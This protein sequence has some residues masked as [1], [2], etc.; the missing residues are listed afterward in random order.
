MAPS[1]RQTIALCAAALLLVSGCAAVLALDGDGEPAA[2]PSGD[3]VAASFQTL[4]SLTATEVRTVE[5]N[6]TTNRTRA[7]VKLA[8][9]DDPRGVERFRRVVAPE[10]DS[11]DV[12]AWR[13]AE[14]VVY[15]ASEAEATRF[16]RPVIPAQFADRGEFYARIAEAARD[17]ETITADRVSPLPVVPASDRTRPVGDA[18]E[19]YEVE[20]LGTETVSGR[21]AHG[22]RLSAVTDAALTANRTLW[23]DAEYYYPLRSA[24][25]AAFENETYH[26]QSALRDV[27]FDADLDAGTF[28][29]SPPSN[30]SVETLGVGEDAYD[31]RAVFVDDAPMSVPRPDVPDGYAFE[32]GRVLDG[33]NY[34]QVVTEYASQRDSAGSMLAV[35]KYAPDNETTASED[36]SPLSAGESVTVAGR[37]ATFL[38]TEYA[39]AVQWR[40]GDVRYTVLATDLEKASVLRVAAS[41]ACE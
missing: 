16:P 37:S 36:A 12:V 30:A 20:Y 8:V 23:L 31:S 7:T 28:A 35:S 26:V 40:C 33:D 19:G 22:F 39:T 9:G 15:D 2:P 32:H 1:S 5:T 10:A 3:E 11:G 4:D 41:V 6:D 14:V 38:R 29:W 27:T 24:R 21:T 13:G 17:G 34:T 18:V 25:T